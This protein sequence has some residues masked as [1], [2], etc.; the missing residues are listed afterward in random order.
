MH[1]INKQHSRMVLKLQTA[2]P[3]WTTFQEHSVLSVGH[4]EVQNFVDEN[5]LVNFLSSLSRVFLV[6]SLCA[7]Q[8]ETSAL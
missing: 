5:K 3:Q 1:W 8:L 4:V 7:E 2:C 6:E